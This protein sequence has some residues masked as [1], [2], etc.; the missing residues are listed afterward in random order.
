[1]FDVHD[2]FTA[3]RPLVVI[4]DAFRSVVPSLDMYL[5]QLLLITYASRSVLYIVC[6]VRRLIVHFSSVCCASD[7][8]LNSGDPHSDG[9]DL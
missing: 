8:Q 9:S 2:A 3:R 5:G 7:V 4:S 6:H 1:M